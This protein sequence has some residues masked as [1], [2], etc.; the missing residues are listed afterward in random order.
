[1]IYKRYG[2]LPW[3]PERLESESLICVETLG[4]LKKKRQKKKKIGN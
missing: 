4:D 3:I 1:M 2:F